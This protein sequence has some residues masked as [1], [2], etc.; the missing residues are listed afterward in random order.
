MSSLRIIAALA[1]SAAAAAAQDGLVDLPSFREGCQALADA[2]FGSATE[3]FS[4]TW[5]TLEAGEAGEIEKNLVASR[6]LESMVRNDDSASATAWMSD[7]ALLS[8]APDTV[9]WM[10]RALKAEE[11]FT[12]AGELFQSLAAFVPD[13]FLYER[14]VCLARSG[15]TDEAFSLIKDREP[16]EQSEILVSIRIAMDAGEDEAARKFLN[17]AEP[18]YAEFNKAPSRENGDLSRENV[19]FAQAS[20]SYQTGRFEEAAARFSELAEELPG[21]KRN[22]SRFNAAIAAL[23]ADQIEAFERQ[24]QA[25]EKNA[26]R[27]PLL[28]DLEYLGGLYLAAQGDPGAFAMLSTFVREHPDHPAN[29]E[30]QLALAEI[31]LNQV[32]ARPQAARK[33][34]EGL[35]LRPLTLT[36][37]ER[38]D[39][40]AVWTELIDLNPPAVIERG[41]TFIN[42]WPNSTYLPDILMIVATKLFEAGNLE[43]AREQFRRLADEFPNAP[44][45]ALA[46]FFAAR[47]AP[48]TPE[49]VSEWE[50]LIEDGG[51]FSTS[52]LHELGL[53]YLS[54]DQFADARTIFSSLIESEH[55]SSE[56]RFAAQADL[57]FSYYSEALAK[58]NDPDLLGQAAD[59]FATLSSNSEASRFWR[60]NAAVR[61][62]KCIEAMGNPSVA[63]EIYRSLVNEV[64]PAIPG[65]ASADE[66]E[67][68]S[69]AGFS[70]INLLTEQEDWA[71]AIKLADTLA[72]KDGPRAIEASRLAE[73]LRLK[74]W[75]WD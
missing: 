39:Y 34:F 67:W 43:G 71:A 2:R 35:R 69:R 18:E 40:S 73:Q 44:N 6:L 50:A 12:E 72:L 1:L 33:I 30:G 23:Q 54:L 53:L 36:Q 13:A 59:V 19:Q 55:D 48:P 26:P 62:G 27:S 14:A 64:A 21:E 4:K 31:H 63:L 3:Q 38:L 42:D 8:P 22:A 7:L 74:H 58:K 65:A 29:V 25:L 11:R 70:A 37:S 52:A 28:A 56:L 51:P 41:S 17:I 9:Y 75:V 66:S 5:K 32:P 45:A 60:F 49:T 24:F 15:E 57:G 20:K 61:R 68:I 16:E 46:E 10:A 47:S